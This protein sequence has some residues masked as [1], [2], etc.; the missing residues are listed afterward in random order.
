MVYL[1]FSFHL[2]YTCHFGIIKYEKL[3]VGLEFA[4]ISSLMHIKYSQGMHSMLKDLA[5]FQ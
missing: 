5:G 1:F 4:M 3:V 2:C